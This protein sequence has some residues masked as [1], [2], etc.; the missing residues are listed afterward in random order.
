MGVAMVAGCIGSSSYEAE[1]SNNTE[2][3]ERCDLTIIEYSSLPQD[4]K[5][6]VDVAFKEGRY[7]TD[8]T[9]F[10][11]SI[12]GPNVQALAKND[13]YYAPQIKTES[14]EHILQFE[15]TTPQYDR[16]RSLRIDNNLEDDP[17]ISITVK[18]SEGMILEEVGQNISNLSE[19]AVSDE[20]GKYTFEI[21]I[22]DRWKGTKTTEM[23]KVTTSIIL[24]VDN[25]ESE[26]ISVKLIQPPNYPSRCPWVN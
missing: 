11:E 13:T 9:L 22:G 2:K 14:G 21:E 17:Y 19:V 23:G 12:T 24:F 16:Q 4:V 18:N 7:T 15:E 25:D 8:G 6:E 3:F 1:N 20:F 26:N 10:W 5:A